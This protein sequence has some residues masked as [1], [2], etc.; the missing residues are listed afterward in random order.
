MQISFRGN[1]EGNALLISVVLIMVLS[2][3]FLTIVPH[4]TALKNIGRQEKAR[5]LAKVERQN[6]EVMEKYDIR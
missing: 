2:L 3:L 6:R 4:I 5:V 1:D